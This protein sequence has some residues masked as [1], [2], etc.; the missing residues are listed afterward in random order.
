M[1]EL[2]ARLKGAEGDLRAHRVAA[3]WF[4]GSV[5]RD[6][7][8]AESDV[9]VLVEFT[10][11]VTLFEFARLRRLLESVLERPVDLVTRD[12][13]KPQLRDQIL[14]EALRAA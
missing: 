9:D 5:A 4:F 3:L 7:A 10:D 2:I 13:L 8:R 11:P 14:R 1:Q 12:A 6:D